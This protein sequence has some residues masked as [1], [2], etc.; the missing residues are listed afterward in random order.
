VRSKWTWITAGVVAFLVVGSIG[1]FRYADSFWLYRGFPPPAL[2]K[3]VTIT[4]GGTTST[5]VPRLGTVE[6]LLVTSP[7]LDGRRQAVMVYLPPGYSTDTTRRYPVFYL[8]HGHPGGPTSFLLAGRMGVEE[9]LLIAE[10]RMTPMILVM[11][12]GSTGFLGPDE[13]WANGVRP[14]NAWETFIAHDVVNYVD[15]HYRTIPT[16]RGRAIG[17]L[18][19]GAYGALNIGIHH[20]DEFGVIESWSGYEEA[21]ALPAIFDRSRRLLDENSPMKTAVSAAPELRALHTYIWFYSGSGEPL[22]PENERFDV[23]LTALGIDHRFFV[24]TGGHS[25]KLWRAE[26]PV[27]LIVASDHLVHAEG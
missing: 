1:A 26:D 14:G 9:S 3:S 5:V 25:W 15:S 18:S 19:E 11:P 13:E 12:Y 7:A 6:S 10:G 27:A 16:A 8:L 21:F 2:P 22:L 17:G 23:L 4:K 24:A 20:P